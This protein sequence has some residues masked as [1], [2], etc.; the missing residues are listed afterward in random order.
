MAK[1][2]NPSCALKTRPV[3]STVDPSFLLLFRFQPSDQLYYR[4]IL[5][6]ATKSPA[7]RKL[8]AAPSWTSDVSFFGSLVVLARATITA[9]PLL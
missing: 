2:P 3:T 5:N 7:H 1:H 9:F 4:M 8:V 6:P